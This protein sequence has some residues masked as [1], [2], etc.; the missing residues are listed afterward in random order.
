LA[1]FGLWLL[2]PAW[3]QAA[4]T[5]PGVT[6]GAAA[7]ITQSTATL[8]GSVD[9]NGAA[10]TYFF[11]YG[12]TSL[13]GLTTGPA[14]A[15]KGS[16]AVPVA[17]AVTGLAPFTRYHYR[18]VAQNAKGLT[19]GKDRSFKTKR[20]PLGLTL[21]AAPDPVSLNRPVTV[22]GTLSGTNNANREVVLQWNPFPYTQGFVNASNPQVTNA[23]GIFAFPLLSLPVNTQFRVLMTDRPDVASPIITVY[24]KVRLTT[25][26]R[27]HRTSRGKIVRFYGSVMPANDGAQF[28]IQRFSKGHW[29][30]VSGGI[31]HHRSAA[32]SHYSKRIRIRH[33]GSYRV[34]VAIVNGQYAS[35]VGRTVHLRRR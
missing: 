11:Q 20:Q 33:A 29:R 24:S 21:G 22:S 13:Y 35:S 23:Q 10:T 1:A 19:K 15:G 31:T 30:T 5:K 16:K 32:S 14:S 7:S 27:T 4:V 12:P 26:L 18:L 9:P 28:A 3:A 6:T 34:F 2:L 25:H 8:T 17:I